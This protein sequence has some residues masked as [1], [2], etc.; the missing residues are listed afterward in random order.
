MRDG[1]TQHV[2]QRGGDALEDISVE[3]IAGA[4]HPKL[5]PRLFARL[6]RGRPHDPAKTRCGAA[7]RRHARLHQAF[8]QFGA[9]PGL[10]GEQAFSLAD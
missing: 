4:G 7:K 9:D 10:L 3:L 2:L 6:R 5:Q 8:L 1:V